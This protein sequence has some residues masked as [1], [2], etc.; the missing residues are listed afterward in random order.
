MN[1]LGASS[2]SLKI[3]V[4]VNF[5]S[6]ITSRGNFVTSAQRATGEAQERRRL[7][8]FYPFS[9]GKLKL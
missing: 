5:T 6:L 2:S 4:V 1:P 9:K 8:G 7:A 3:L